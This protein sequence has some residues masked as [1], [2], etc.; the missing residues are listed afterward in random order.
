MPAPIRIGLA[1]VEYADR[2]LVGV[3]GE[4]S[5]L[6]GFAEFP[7]GKCEV[8]ES[9]A[10]CAVRECLEET[11]LIVRAVRLLEERTHDYAHGTV[12]LHFWLC[13]AVDP[14]KIADRHQ[15]FRWVSR[16]ELKTVNFPAAN[17]PVIALLTREA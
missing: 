6:P 16:E 11:G 5:P 15:G 14:E 3:R 13:E 8:D 17:E 4:E 1:V 10:D 2:F 9:P 12:Q 7:G